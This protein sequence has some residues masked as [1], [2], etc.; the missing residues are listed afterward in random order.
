MNLIHFVRFPIRSQICTDLQISSS[1]SVII[2]PAVSLTF[3]KWRQFCCFILENNNQSNLTVLVGSSNPCRSLCIDK[4]WSGLHEVASLQRITAPLISARP[5][6]DISPAQELSEGD[7]I[8]ID[9]TPSDCT[10][11]AKPNDLHEDPFSV[12]HRLATS[13]V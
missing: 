4:R 6:F 9:T 3:V 5:F 7:D 2:S 10:R 13:V 12:R 8:D 1:T 11:F